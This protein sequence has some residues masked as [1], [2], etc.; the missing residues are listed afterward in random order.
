MK[1]TLLLLCCVVALLI[2]SCKEPF[3]PPDVATPTPKLVV[4]GVLV[5]GGKP[6][7]IRLSLTT[8][9]TNQTNIVPEVNATVTV[10]GKDNTV[11]PLLT[12]GLGI[13]TSPALNL[14]IGN[15]YRVRIKR[16]GGKE[17]LSDY[18]TVK[19]TPLIDSIGW[20]RLP[21]EALEVY[22]N[23]HDPSNKTIYYRWDYDET[24]EIRSQHPSSFI[25][26]GGV[27]VRSRVPGEEVT[28]CWKY[29]PSSTIVVGSS[30][31]L[32]SDIISKAPVASFSKG[33]EK[34]AVRYSI[35]L[36]Q[37]AI[38]KT[39]YEFFDLMKKN[40]EILGSIFDPQP[41]ELTGNFHGVANPK[42]QVIG[43]VTA[44]TV[45]EK[46]AFIS[47]A[48]LGDWVYPEFCMITNT[49]NDPDSIRLTYSGG[50]FIPFGTI[51]NGAD[52]IYFLTSTAP[53]VDCTKRNG[54]VVK[55][56]YW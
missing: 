3:D 6:T 50:A 45:Q 42:E 36:R 12:T 17:Y 56:P 41:S 2:V 46:R 32:Q 47:V 7:S 20:R 26:D 9:L 19:S 24:W 28:V 25:Y 29:A 33:D 34:L 11:Q 48:D 13:Y 37:Y 35:L 54:S 14:T 51:M 23:A 18:V 27:H 44:S 52:T 49:K 39:A 21:G 22:A 43:Y 38:D 15:E 40:T 10:E 53:C 30:A 1:R 8:R 5:A 31:K 16:S 55:P 4:E